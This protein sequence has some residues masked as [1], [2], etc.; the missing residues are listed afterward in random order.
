MADNWYREQWADAGAALS[1]AIEE[2]LLERQSEYQLLE[3]YQTTHFGKLLTLDGLVMVTQRDHFI[4]HEMLAHPA[5][6][7]HPDPHRVAIIGGGDCGLLTE[8]LKHDSVAIATQVEIDAAVTDVAV[9]H[10]PE[11]AAARDDPRSDLVFGDGAAWIRDVEDGGLD[12]LLVDSTDPIG[13][14]AQ[15]FEQPFLEQC[16]RV[17]GA[18]GVFA[19]QS[20]SP[21]FHADLIRNVQTSLRACGWSDVATLTFPQCTYPSGWWSVT[22]A[23]YGDLSGYR[24]LPESLQTRYYTGDIHRGAMALP[25]FLRPG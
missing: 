17:L 12:V 13:P 8:V 18:S 4:Y 5:L 10:F 22:L 16:R 19:M 2:K 25:R 9:A 1:L 6:L 14:A 15:L 11:F 21:L 23:G 24:D 3:V 7:T 20:E